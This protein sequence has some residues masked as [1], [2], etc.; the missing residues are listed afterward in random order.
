MR[1]N[2]SSCQR[3]LE[4]CP[5]GAV[6]LDRSLAIDPD[7]CRGCLLCSAVCPVGALEAG[8]DFFLCLAQLSK[9]PEPVLGCL[10]S[11]DSSN[12]TLAC[13]GG[14]A[15]EH[16]LVLYHTREG[17]LT[18]NLT[19]CADCPNSSMMIQLRQRLDTMANAGLSGGKCRIVLTE[20]TKDLH[21]CEEAVDRRS[22]FKSFGHYLFKGADNILFPPNEQGRQRSEYAE[23]R[24]PLRRQLL[25][26]TRS[27]LSPELELRV[28]KNFDSTVSFSEDCTSCQGCVAICPTGALQTESADMP[29]AFEQQ[30]CTGC[31]L[32]REF[33]LD[34]AVQVVSGKCGVDQDD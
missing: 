14:L 22:F 17:K 2:A 13:L 23:K 20:S 26:R 1:F 16:L 34:E 5:H 11:K 4:I 28:Q 30:M 6:P 3:C 31:G 12:A 24:I 29:P 7:K 8:S 25:N 19:S 27:V 15:E 33:C 18:L 21:Y 9:V 32:C 10:R